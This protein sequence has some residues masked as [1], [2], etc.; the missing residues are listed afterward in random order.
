MVIG[1][2][3]EVVVLLEME[4]NGLNG[5]CRAQMDMTIRYCSSKTFFKLTPFNES[6]SFDVLYV[7]FVQLILLTL[8]N[9]TTCRIVEEHSTRQ[10][11]WLL[12]TTPFVSTQVTRTSDWLF[13]KLHILNTADREALPPRFPRI[14]TTLSRRLCLC[15][16]TSTR[17]ERTPTPSSDSFS[18]SLESTD[19]PDTTSLLVFCPPP[20]ST[21]PPLLPL[22]STRVFSGCTLHKNENA[23]A[24]IYHQDE[25][26]ERSSSVSDS[27]YHAVKEVR[28]TSEQPWEEVNMW[29]YQN[30]R[31]SRPKR[32]STTCTLHSSIIRLN[33]YLLYY[34]TYYTSP[35]VRATVRTYWALGL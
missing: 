30:L 1:I 15:E 34:T 2:N 24:P 20:G 26:R 10:T 14:S 22:L 18:S 12:Q 8:V 21:S 16:S 5:F 32:I 28:T 33:H 7:S 27:I 23:L 9:A 13:E 6:A 31:S 17:T 35:S 25:I 4:Q 19:L 11:V 29:G 3:T